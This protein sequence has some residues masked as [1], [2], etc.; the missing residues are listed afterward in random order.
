MPQKK[1]LDH[2][3]QLGLPEFKAS[4]LLV[5]LCERNG[6]SEL[7]TTSFIMSNPQ[8]CSRDE[9]NECF[10]YLLSRNWI[11]FDDSKKVF[12]ANNKKIL[13]E[14]DFIEILQRRNELFETLG[15]PHESLAMDSLHNFFDDTN[16]ILYI[17]TEVTDPK[18]FKRLHSR[19]KNQKKTV[20]ILPN[21]KDCNDKSGYSDMLAKWKEIISNEPLI[22]SDNLEIRISRKPHEDLYTSSLSNSAARLNIYTLGSKTRTGKLI[23]VAKGSSLYMLIEDKYASIYSFST[24]SFTIHP[25]KYLLEN[26][27]FLLLPPIITLIFFVN[28]TESTGGLKITATILLSILSGL[29]GDLFKK[30]TWSKRQLWKK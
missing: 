30:L 18:V 12:R 28:M 26:I 2:L 1:A 13:L 10:Q 8:R 17:S 16:S 19:A 14:D 29:A 21:R 25:F 27:K 22:Y 3:I 20:I 4:A 6:L 24:P 15:H 11:Y 7:H 23:K 9:A 5:F